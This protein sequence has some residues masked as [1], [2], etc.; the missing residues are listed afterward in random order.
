MSYAKPPEER[1]RRNK[2]KPI[3]SSPSGVK[4][5]QAPIT[6]SS[7][8][9]S[10]W[11]KFWRSS[12]AE[13]VD[14]VSDLPSVERLFRLYQLASRLMAKIEADDIP[15]A[16]D[17]STLTK[18][19]SE[20]RLTEAGLGLSPRSRLAL[21]VTLSASGRSSGLDEFLGDD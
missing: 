6:I 20:I 16:A 4:V 13:L 5:P 17:I 15:A 14:P 19:S 21:G 1:Q 12:A 8:L 7:E 2:P 18:L 10:A 9:R 3:A 11:R